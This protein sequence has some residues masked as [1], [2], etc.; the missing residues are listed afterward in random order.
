MPIHDWTRVNAGI[1]HH[2]HN[3][4]ISA[5]GH[6]LNGGVLPDNYYA[7]AEQFAG[8]VGPDV[9]ALERRESASDSW[10]GA[11]SPHSQGVL[12]VVEH[13]P[14]VSIT[15]SS[16]HAFYAQKQQTLVIRHV[17]DDRIIA[18]IEI[19]S[20]GNKSSQT[21]IQKFLDKVCSALE[22]GYHLLILD[23]HP[24]TSRDPNGIHGAIWSAIGEED[25]RAPQNKPLTLAGY[26]AGV[27][28]RAYIEPT[29][30][31]ETL[32]D[33]PLFLE[34][35]SYVK[36]PLEVSYLQAWQDVPSRWRSELDPQ[37]K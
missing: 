33:M 4:W 5:I 26:S 32:R 8:D 19:V 22:Q 35:G 2:F 12:A 29:A 7:L 31:G 23:L 1:F 6:H 16:E 11:T 17:S 34:P 36:V 9:L 3:S 13:P 10:E 21:A 24:P 28:T 14:E 18:L 37:A 15:A 30:V 20:P 25:Y 27:C